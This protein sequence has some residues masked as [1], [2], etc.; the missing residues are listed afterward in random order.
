MFNNRSAK[1]VTVS[2]EAMNYY[3]FIGNKLGFVLAFSYHY[4]KLQV[5]W[6]NTNVLF[7]NSVGL[8]TDRPVRHRSN[9]EV[10]AGLCSFLQVVGED[11]FPC[12]LRFL[13]EPFSLQ[14]EDWDPCFLVGYQMRTVPSFLGWSLQSLAGHT[15]FLHLQSQQGQAK[16][17]SSFK[18][19]LLLS[20]YL[21][22]TVRKGSLFFGTRD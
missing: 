13:A 2:T 12:S 5:Y 11:L 16:S 1:K 6:L 4:N 20:S 9:T 7:Y 17:F 10:S 15:M 22:D 18:P 3:P 8:T 19:L 14:F 21:S